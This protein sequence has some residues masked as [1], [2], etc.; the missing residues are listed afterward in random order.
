MIRKKVR[1]YKVGHKRSIK[2]WR[3]SLVGV[4]AFIIG[5]G[6]SLENINLSIL[7]SY[8]TIGINRAFY[9][10]DTTIIM[11]QDEQ[12]WYSDKH[13]IS[14]LKAIKY[15]RDRSDPQNR[16]YN[17]RR[18]AGDYQMPENPSVLYGMGST[19]PLAFQ[20]AFIL[21]CDPIVLLGMDCK[22]IDGKTD[23]YGKN[24]SHKPHTLRNCRKGLK[25]ITK[26]H[27]QKTI[28]NC[29]KNDVFSETLSLEDALIQV[30][31]DHQSRESLVKR[32]MHISS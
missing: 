14:R 12:L 4:P 22:Y 16:F 27:D 7:K 25:W 21:G 3:N 2:G 17:F 1:A 28:I 20:L 24:P 18:V 13:R 8:F 15:C 5:N 31:A 29:S 10:L 6:P 32:L 11:W 9:K 30:N 23:F 26:Y 19:G